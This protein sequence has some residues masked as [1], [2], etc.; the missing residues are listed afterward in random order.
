MMRNFISIKE[1]S[2]EEVIEAIFTIYK[3]YVCVVI[4][5]TLKHIIPLYSDER[6]TLAKKIIQK[7]KKL[8]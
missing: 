4:V 6:L 2:K 1:L 3:K 7:Q 8:S 5:I